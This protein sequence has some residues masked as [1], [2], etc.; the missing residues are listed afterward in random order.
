MPSLNLPANSKYTFKDFEAEFP[1]DAAC[2][3]KLVELLYPHG[4]HCLK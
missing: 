1:N 2:L 4:I 3:R